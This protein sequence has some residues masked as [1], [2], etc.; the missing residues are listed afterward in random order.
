MM[1]IT[2]NEEVVNLKKKLKSMHVIILLV[3]FTLVLSGCQIV[4][5]V[6]LSQILPKQLDV[7]SSEG[8]L[9]LEVQLALNDAYQGDEK[10]EN[11]K[12]TKIHIDS[13]KIE[14][15]RKASLK[16]SFEYA[17]GQIP[18]Q[19]ELNGVHAYLQI[20]GLSKPIEIPVVNPLIQSKDE[21]FKNVATLIGKNLPN[22]SNLQVDS[23]V[24]TIHG[25]EVSG[26]EVS[27]NLNTTQILEG[28]KSLI[29]SLS[30]DTEGLKELATLIYDTDYYSESVDQVYEELQSNLKDAQEVL[31]D[32]TPGDINTD[33]KIFV[34]KDLN[35][36][37]STGS[38]DLTLDEY[39]ESPIKQVLVKWDFERWSIN[40]SVTTDKIDRS[41]GIMKEK[42]L[43][44]PS[45]LF[46]Q[47]NKDSQFYNLLTD[48]V[49]MNLIQFG[50]GIKT[51]QELNQAKED[52]DLDYS[53]YNYVYRNAQGVTYVGL[54]QLSERLGATV[55][56]DAKNEQ[57][58][59]KRNGK[60]IR[61]AMGS[62]VAF[63]ND[64]P[65][66]L[67]ENVFQI[68]GVTLVPLRLVSETFGA[69]IHYNAERNDVV[70]FM[71][72]LK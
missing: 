6:N 59:V 52:N 27:L 10:F 67:S 13:Y 54:R 5:G 68:D 14:N 51:P 18:F 24:E 20:E 44:D 49:K 26:Y 38:L 50:Y 1:I 60:E 48:E 34:D 45:L 71:D 28:L 4:N 11:F 7:K 61:L 42:D 46:A 40:Q 58:L 43:H 57:I 53:Q 15:D 12:L 62:N 25:D 63:V 17:K 9:N 32:P 31:N 39:E 36:R 56:W 29:Q 19:I 23:K 35:I 65:V 66:K 22:A 70:V 69:T 21:L 64:K 41:P 30:E 8:S 47:V 37:K 2:K 72:I 55:A 16:G 3:I 33:L